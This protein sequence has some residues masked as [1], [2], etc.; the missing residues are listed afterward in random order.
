[1]GISLTPGNQLRELTFL[2]SVMTWTTA[3]SGTSTLSNNFSLKKVREELDDVLSKQAD[4]SIIIQQKDQEWD[5]WVD[6]RTRFSVIFG[7]KQ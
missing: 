3:L 5:E 4:Q 6:L 1:M 7:R 2:S